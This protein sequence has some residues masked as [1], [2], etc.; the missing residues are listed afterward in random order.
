MRLRDVTPAVGYAQWLSLGYRGTLHA[1]FK[2]L[3][4]WDA[5]DVGYNSS[6]S[7][8]FAGD[9]QTAIDI[10][11]KD[12]SDLKSMILN[13]PSLIEAGDNI[14]LENVDGTLIISALVS[15][16][17]KGDTGDMGP[18]GVPG[19]KGDTGE[20]GEKGDTGSRGHAGPP[21]IPG[22]GF[23]DVSAF[24]DGSVLVVQDGVLVAIP[25]SS[26]GGGGSG[27]PGVKGDTGPTG[28]KGDSGEQGPVGDTG[29]TGDAGLTGEKGDT[30]A[31]GDTGPAGDPGEKGE[32][33]PIGETGPP[34]VPGESMICNCDIPM[35]LLKIENLEKRIKLLENPTTSETWE[36]YFTVPGGVWEVLLWTLPGFDKT[37]PFDDCF[38]N[39]AIIEL[40]VTSSNNNVWTEPGVRIPSYYE[41]PA[42]SGPA[43]QFGSFYIDPDVGMLV[44]TSGAANNKAMK[45]IKVE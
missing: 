10:L 6:A 30:G 11:A 32:T 25:L 12:T 8:L 18:P 43:A 31:T 27:L 42:S 1:F 29:A 36:Y 22:D 19:D 17:P 26:I 14:S 2:W 20:K 7:G 5:I 21:G 9:V 23:L 15:E 3:L 37:L 16:G 38:A 24:E 44:L 35:L 33:G 41:P 34:G 13:L 4:L 40:Y 28:P 45:L 39:P